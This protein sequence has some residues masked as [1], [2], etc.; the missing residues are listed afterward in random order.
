MF[1]IRL[2]EF[3]YISLIIIIPIDGKVIKNFKYSPFNRNGYMLRGECVRMVNIP[4]GLIS[5]QQCLRTL[6]ADT[7]RLCGRTQS[8]SESFGERRS[9]V[10]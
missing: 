8:E 6:H 5:T 1:H 9:S 10:L 4:L 7:A 2:N 3:T